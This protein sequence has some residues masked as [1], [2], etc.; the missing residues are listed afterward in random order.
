MKSQLI[1]VFACGLVACGS[2]ENSRYRNTAMLEKPPTLALQKTPQ[3][4]VID[5]SIEPKK[6]VGGLDEKVVLLDESPKKLV[7][8]QSISESWRTVGTALRQSDIKITDTDKAKYS[9]YVSYKLQGI[10]KNILSALNEEE[11]K[12]VYLVTLTP[13]NGDTLI[14]A[15]L[16]NR[17]E[18]RSQ[19]ADENVMQVTDDSEGLVE[20]LY[21]LLRDDVKTE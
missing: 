20:S 21:H 2:I 8:K 9:Y 10:L 6:Q 5:D 12:T 13:Q 3:N 19:N 1:L 14:Q 4:A 15:S 11:T 17:N 16:A 7:L 18:Q